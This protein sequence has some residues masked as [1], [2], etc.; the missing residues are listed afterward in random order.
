MGRDDELGA[1]LEVFGSVVVELFAGYHLAGERGLR[2]V[3]AQHRALQFAGLLL[4]AADA[5]LNDDLAIIFGGRV[6]SAWQFL[7]VVRFGNSYG[8][9][10]I[11]R[12]YEHWVLQLA[13]DRTLYSFRVFVP[14]APQHRHMLHDW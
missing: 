8:R 9:S 1:F 4:L 13:L 10:Q 12:L 6:H 7:A 11:G 2:V 5:L 3:V 14:V